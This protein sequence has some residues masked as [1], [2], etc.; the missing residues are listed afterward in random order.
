LPAISSLALPLGLAPPF[1]SA[2]IAE[3]LAEPQRRLTVG[4]TPN[5]RLDDRVVNPLILLSN[6]RL[7]SRILHETQVWIFIVFGT[8][9]TVLEVSTWLTFHNPAFARLSK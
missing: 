2:F 5:I 6:P 7:E 3:L 8:E 4:T 9:Y 1:L